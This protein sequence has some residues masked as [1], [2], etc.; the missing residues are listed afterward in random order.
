VFVVWLIGL[1]LAVAA[2]VVLVLAVRRWVD[3]RTR[4]GATAVLAGGLAGAAVGFFLSTL[5]E[6]VAER[7]VDTLN[8]YWYAVAAAGFTIGALVGLLVHGG[9]AAGERIADRERDSA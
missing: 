3:S 9:Q 1:A 5:V 2:P 7:R 4:R 8:D 6:F